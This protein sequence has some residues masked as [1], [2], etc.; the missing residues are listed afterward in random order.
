MSPFQ[1]SVHALDARTIPLPSRAGTR[2]VAQ[3]GSVLFTAMMLLI[4][5]SLLALSAATVTAMQERMASTYRA[6][7]RAFEHAEARLRSAENAIAEDLDPCHAAEAFPSDEWMSTPPSEG[8]QSYRNMS[9][10]SGS[11][12]FGWRGS[13]K[14]G[15]P[16]LVGDIQ[17]AYFR[18]AAVNSDM[19]GVEATSSA[20]VTSVYVP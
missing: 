4:V 3:N 6:E 12:G 19:P 17:C 14:A 20:I 13:S 18:V 9:R 11:L 16:A 1:T 5:L 10:G 2:A 7:H 15:Q 8:A